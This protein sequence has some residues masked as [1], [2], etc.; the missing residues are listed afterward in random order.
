MIV[1][2]CRR[3]ELGEEKNSNERAVDLVNEFVENVS[4][5][6]GTF[7]AGLSDPQDNVNGNVPGN[8]LEMLLDRNSVI[9][10]E[11]AHRDLQHELAHNLWTQKGEE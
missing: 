4:H 6:L 1:D 8:G 3:D 10:S 9:K 5:L 2:M 11:T 7:P